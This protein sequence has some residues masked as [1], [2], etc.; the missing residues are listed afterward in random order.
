MADAIDYLVGLLTAEKATKFRDAKQRLD[1]AQVEQKAALVALEGVVASVETIARVRRCTLAAEAAHNEVVNL[2][3][4]ALGN[5][6][7]ATPENVDAAQKTIGERRANAR[8]TFVETWKK[9]DEVEQSMQRLES[10]ALNPKGP[11]GSD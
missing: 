6:P 7:S 10:K 3:L 5:A 1:R 2:L 9:I 8:S 4:E 11:K